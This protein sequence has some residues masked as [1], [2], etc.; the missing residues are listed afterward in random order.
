MSCETTKGPAFGLLT[1]D[2]R[3]NWAEARV[4]LLKPTGNKESVEVIQRALFTV[5]LDDDVTAKNNEIL[6]VNGLQLI[7]GGGSQQNAAN[8]W[9]DKTIQVGLNA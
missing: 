1:T 5:S 6:N 7:H 9:M 8:R 2:T 3:D 4:E